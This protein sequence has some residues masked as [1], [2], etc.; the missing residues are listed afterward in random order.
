M[1]SEINVAYT[2]IVIFRTSGSYIDYN[3]YNCQELGLAK[4]LAKRGYRVSLIM[5]GPQS[6]HIKYENIGCNIDIYYL[7]YKSINQSLCVFDGWKQ[8][9]D[10]LKPNVIQVHEFGMYMSYL[11]SRWAK[12][13]NI[14]CV[15]IQGNYNTTLKPVLKQLE[16]IFNCTFG[17]ST[18]KKV[19][20]IGCKTDAAERYVKKYS[21]KKMVITPI[22][23]DE[24]KFNNCRIINDFRQQY[25][26]TDKKLMLYVGK[27]ESRRNPFFLLKLMKQLSDDY[28]LVLVGDGPLFEQVRCIIKNEDIN[29]V[30]VLGK[31]NQEDLPTLYASADLF[32]L[33]SSYEIYGMVILESM[34]FGCPVLST[35]T[36]GAEVLIENNKNGIIIDG[37]LDID[38]WIDKIHELFTKPEILKNMG[39]N[40]SDKI[41]MQLVWDRACQN[42][43]NV[44]GFLS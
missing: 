24:S 35:M 7:S 11:V 21:N 27:M 1:L 16:K 12:N 22:G 8:L 4:A 32:L 34:F 2:H 38:K 31:K 26:L 23:L 44:Y 15:L 39:K 6:S 25:G 33:A 30:I 9:L 20:A 42:F 13:H 36:A 18:L 40:A 29:N 10:Q 19:D 5:G 3:I 43:I 17:K 41:K 37:N 14:R 28:C